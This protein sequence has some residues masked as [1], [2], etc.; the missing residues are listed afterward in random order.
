MS[1]CFCGVGKQTEE[2][3][4]IW[5][6]QWQNLQPPSCW[7]ASEIWESPF[8][9]LRRFQT[10][11]DQVPPRL[12]AWSRQKHDGD[13]FKWGA[14]RAP[15]LSLFKTRLLLSP[16]TPSPAQECKAQAGQRVQ[17]DSALWDTPA[18]SS[19]CTPVL[20][21]PRMEGNKHIIFQARDSSF[22]PLVACLFAD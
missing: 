14:I 2:R 9:M 22:P 17:S 19:L 8:W 1:T 21:P 5:Q 11:I 12:G 16:P 15:A 20:W 18:P 10:R 6:R 4:V 3:G 7:H 13:C